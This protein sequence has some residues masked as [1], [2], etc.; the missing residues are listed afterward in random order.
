[1]QENRPTSAFGVT[2]GLASSSVPLGK[3]TKTNLPNFRQAIFKNVKNCNKNFETPAEFFL[4]G[5][6]NA[7]RRK[8]GKETTNQ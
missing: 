8:L 7:M 3:A 1:M 5:S 2:S 4:G 6:K